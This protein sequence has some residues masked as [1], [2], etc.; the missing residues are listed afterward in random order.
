MNV[1]ELKAVLTVCLFVGSL[2]V[3]LSPLAFALLSR[4]CATLLQRRSFATALAAL[5]CVGGGVFLGVAFLHL[6]PEVTRGISASFGLINA[7]FG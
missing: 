4:R 6:L 5:N 1:A 2:L 3:G 7:E